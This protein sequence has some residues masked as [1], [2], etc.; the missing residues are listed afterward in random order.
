M[1][2]NMVLFLPRDA[3]SVPVSRKV[4]DRCLESLGV[5]P[6]TR[7]DIA[8]AL[9]EACA[10]VVQ[11]AG[12]DDEYEVRVSAKNRQC[13]IEVVNTGSENAE[14]SAGH[15]SAASPGIALSDGPVP[16]TAEHGR[17]LKLIDAVVDKLRLTGDRNQ[18]ATV[19]FEKTLEWLPGAPGQQLLD[20]DDGSSA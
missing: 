14:P 11:H 18:G 6:D 9:T 20:A 7:G 4:L 12:S 16:V 17:G 2:V 1:E 3:V 8:L 5:T 19:H 10:N 13:I 15:G